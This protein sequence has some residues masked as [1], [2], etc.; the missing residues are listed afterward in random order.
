MGTRKKKEDV[1][2]K[3]VLG[4]NSVAN[5]IT[6]KPCTLIFGHIIFRK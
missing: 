3:T 2:V 4:M 1:K 6:N 5:L